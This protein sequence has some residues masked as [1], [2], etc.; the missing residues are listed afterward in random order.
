MPPSVTMT[1]SAASASDAEQP[2]LITGK[3]C[4]CEDENV[5]L[6]SVLARHFN[7]NVC[8][9]CKQDRNLRFGWYELIPKTR[10]KSEFALPD[11]Y[12][13]GIPFVTKPNPRH[14]SFAPLKLYLKKMMIDEATRL[15]GD[16][17]TLEKEKTSRKRKS[18]ER[19]A[20]RT[21]H[22]MK[23][24]HAIASSE[25]SSA[26]EGT[27]G[28]SSKANQ[29]P[30]KLEYIPVADRDHQ[31]QYAPEQFEEATNLWVKECACGVKVQ[32]EK[33]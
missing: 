22:L 8:I 31:H 24:R 19:A 10:A 15:Y 21:K 16:E 18:Y 6:D 1:T 25:S 5:V 4:E 17:A 14:E 33:W 28:R 7:V 23:K 13:H 30:R 3:C 26:D 29:E 2:K 12:F 32:F 27:R 20:T 11:S 9:L